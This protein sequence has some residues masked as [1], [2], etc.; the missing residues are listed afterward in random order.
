MIRVDVNPE[1]LRW[2]RERAGLATDD[3]ISRFPKLEVWEH[4]A[5]KPTLKQIEKFAAATHTP[6]GFLFLPQPPVENIP[7][8]DF[9]TV[10]N[11]RIQR[12]TP[13]LLDTIYICQQRQE[14]YRDFARSEHI[15]PLSFV[16]SANINS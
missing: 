5:A 9:R 8:P 15:S 6:I 3:L 11:R 7:I 2:A 14:W 10:R 1:L 4:G 13:D 16:G 12:P